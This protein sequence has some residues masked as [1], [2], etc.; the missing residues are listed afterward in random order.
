M[1]CKTAPEAECKP[2]KK[3]DVKHKLQEFVL[4]KKQREILNSIS[5]LAHQEADT[6]DT[7]AATSEMESADAEVSSLL[8]ASASV[9]KVVPRISPVQEDE[10][11]PALAAVY[12]CSPRSCGSRSVASPFGCELLGSGLGSSSSSLLEEAGGR[13][14]A[15]P[16][17]ASPPRHGK[18]RPVG[19]TQS[20]P[21]PLGHPALLAPPPP[22][23]GSSAGGSPDPDTMAHLLGQVRTN[24]SAACGHVT[25]I[26]PLIGQVPSSSLVKQQIRH[27]VLSRHHRATAAT[28]P[29]SVPGPSAADTAAYRSAVTLGAAYIQSVQSVLI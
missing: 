24:E 4:Q 26:S 25:R 5:S 10:A 2:A 3:S 28:S 11:A 22:P 16:Y 1:G 9:F 15:P 18:L 27:S 21:L 13:Y 6:R 12:G 29:P 20:A 7:E 14:L 17:T 8:S 23:P 19:R